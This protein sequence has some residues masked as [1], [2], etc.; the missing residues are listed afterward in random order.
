MTLLNSK[1]T[2][3]LGVFLHEATTAPFT[4]PATKALHGIDLEYGDISYL[5]WAYEQDVPRTGFA[6]GHAADVAPPV[7]W[8]NR[9]LALERNQEIERVWRQR[10]QKGKDSVKP[11]EGEQNGAAT[12]EVCAQG[13]PKVK[14]TPPLRR[15][16]TLTS[17]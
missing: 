11:I 10:R 6:I 9:H 3:F 17:G 15:P 14:D 16:F 2:R 4:G 5:A 12:D 7:P 1:E 8:P 13:H